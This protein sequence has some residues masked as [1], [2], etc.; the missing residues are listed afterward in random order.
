[1]FSAGGDFSSPANPHRKKAREGAPPQVKTPPPPL[2]LGGGGRRM[3]RLAAR[4][5]DIVHVNYNLNEGRIN[6]KLVRTG[7]AEATDEKLGWI[8]E[9]AGDRLE[10]IDLGFTIFFASITDD[11]ESL[12]S[13]LAPSMGFEPQD[14][15]EMPHFLIGTVAQI[16]EDLRARRERY[17]FSH[18]ILPGESADELSRSWSDSPANNSLR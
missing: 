17:G 18:V 13:A 11:R 4:E 12:A 5:A 16:E 3:L 15:L 10:A 14:V 9:A 1:M 7:M 6:P 8:K 2:L